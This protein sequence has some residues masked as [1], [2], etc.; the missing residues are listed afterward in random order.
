MLLNAFN[1]DIKFIKGE[2][3]AMA[4]AI[5]RAYVLKENETKS[6][7]IKQKISK[8]CDLTNRDNRKWVIIKDEQAK[9]VIKFIHRTSAYADLNA[10]Y[11]NIKDFYRVSGIKRILKETV[12]KEMKNR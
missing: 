9:E 5:S 11:Y 4:D 2:N 12:M 3:N 8:Y 10:C 7:R 6:I 1:F